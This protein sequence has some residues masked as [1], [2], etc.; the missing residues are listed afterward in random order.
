MLWNKICRIFAVIIKFLKK[1]AKPINI[2]PVLRG[3]DAISFLTKIKANS[4]RKVKVSTLQNISKDANA[5]R[6]IAK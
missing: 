4:V 1:M 3:K 5:L 2:T 6:A